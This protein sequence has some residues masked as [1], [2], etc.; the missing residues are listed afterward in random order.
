MPFS[1]GLR[2]FRDFIGALTSALFTLYTSTLY[3][4]NVPI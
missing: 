4:I 1:K 3:L 2:Y